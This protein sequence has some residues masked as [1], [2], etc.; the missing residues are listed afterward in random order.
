VNGQRSPYRR[1]PPS[2]NRSP[3]LQVQANPSR[4]G[5]DSELVPALGKQVLIDCPQRLAWRGFR[6]TGRKLTIGIF[7]DRP[8]ILEFGCRKPF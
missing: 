5:V 3:K 8:L 4:E 2:V 6:G 7:F 1:R